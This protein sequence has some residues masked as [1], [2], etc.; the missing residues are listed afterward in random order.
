MCK[1][2]LSESIKIYYLFC[3]F[4]HPKCCYNCTKVQW[5]IW[6]PDKHFSVW[7]SNGSVSTWSGYSYLVSVKGVFSPVPPNGWANSPNHLKTKH[8]K[9]L[10]FVR[11]SN[12]WAVQ[13]SNDIWKPDHLAPQ[14]L[15]TIQNWYNSGIQIPA[16][17]YIF[18]NVLFSAASCM[19]MSRIWVT[20]VRPAFSC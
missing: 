11:F 14:Q 12:C 2:F 17:F 4:L 13:Y 15:S 5:E 20:I 7:Y 18:L 3:I 16:V 1:L 10:P 6:I 9:W 19:P 8:S